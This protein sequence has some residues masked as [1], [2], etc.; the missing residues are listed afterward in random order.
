MMTNIKTSTVN[1][2]FISLITILGGLSCSK[3]G[4]GKINHIIRYTT[5]DYNKSSG[6]NLKSAGN[7]GEQTYSGFGDYITSITPKKFTAKL[8]MMYYM[9]NW[10]WNGNIHVVS[11][12]DQ[13]VRQAGQ[14]QFIDFSDNQEVVLTPEL[15]SKDLVG[16]TFRQK[17][18]TFI[19]FVFV[20]WYIYQEM[21]LPTEYENVRLNQFDE[22][23][24]EWIAP[25]YGGTQY[26]CDTM[27]AGTLLKSRHAP[28]TSRLFDGEVINYFVFG[29]TDSTFVFNREKNP[30]NPSK[31]W[32]FGGGGSRSIVIRSNKFTPGKVV[33]P[34][35][36]QSTTM[37]STVVFDTQNLIQAYAG[38]DNIPYTS[39]DLLL[40]APKFWERMD[41][42]LELK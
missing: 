18:V 12:I 33:M 37:M 13:L 25:N 41:V 22:Y 39:D 32:P 38:I 9:D 24:R 40:Y 17:E 42:K 3:E 20:P 4:G 28:F 15:G 31:D 19:Y 11:Y 6:N 26:N 27:K 21:D 23:Y 1:F 8:L 10:D 2:V 35:D 34:D 16:N 29:N 7:N 30:I 14:E 36:G 5:S